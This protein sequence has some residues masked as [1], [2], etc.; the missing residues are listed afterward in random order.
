MRQIKDKRKRIEFLCA[1]NCEFSSILDLTFKGEIPA[2]LNAAPSFGDE[3]IVKVESENHVVVACFDWQGLNT[4]S[5]DSLAR[6][7]FPIKLVVDLVDRVIQDFLPSPP[8]PE[9]PEEMRYKFMRFI[10]SKLH[11]LQEPD[12]G[13][14]CADSYDDKFRLF[15]YPFVVD[16]NALVFDWSGASIGSRTSRTVSIWVAAKVEEF[17]VQQIGDDE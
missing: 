5:D 12:E 17:L 6:V 3:F 2:L 16:S 7:G 11:A 4:R 13:Y 8:A 1:L 9:V 14:W 10:T 15:E